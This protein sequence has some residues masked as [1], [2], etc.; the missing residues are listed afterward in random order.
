MATVGHQCEV[1]LLV[2]GLVDPPKEMAR[3]EEKISRLS[4][5]LEKLSVAMSKERYEEKVSS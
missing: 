5:Q 3:L 2:K 4:S 1:H